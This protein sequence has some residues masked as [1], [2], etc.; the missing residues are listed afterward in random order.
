MSKL[1]RSKSIFSRAFGSFFGWFEPRKWSNYDGAKQDAF[2]LL[3]LL[4]GTLSRDPETGRRR[5][6]QQHESFDS[7]VAKSNMSEESVAHTIKVTFWYAMLYFIAAACVFAYAFFILHKGMII[8]TVVTFLLSAMLFFQGVHQHIL[9]L[10]LR[11][12]TLSIVLK[13]WFGVVCGKEPPKD[14]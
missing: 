8:S 11:H 10:R 6:R 13:D 5:K 3:R 9:S 4:R 7:F 14:K 12:R 2:F 1:S